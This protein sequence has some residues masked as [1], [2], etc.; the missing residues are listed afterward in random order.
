MP[1]AMVMASIFVPIY[2]WFWPLL[3]VAVIGLLGGIFSP[4]RS[5]QRGCLVVGSL[6]L[7]LAL[8][9]FVVVFIHE[10]DKITF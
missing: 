5:P 4:R 10:L 9:L 8:G 1:G 6:A 7:L 3:A 2:R